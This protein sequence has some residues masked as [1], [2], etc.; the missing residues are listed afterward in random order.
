M[1]FVRGVSGKARKNSVNLTVMKR[2][3]DT[4]EVTPSANVSPFW[5][6]EYEEALMGGGETER[7]V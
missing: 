6:C 1:R 7:S 4:S 3:I 5:Q 2:C